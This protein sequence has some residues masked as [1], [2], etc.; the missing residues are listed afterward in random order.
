MLA[1]W[2]LVIGICLMGAMTPGASLAVVL[3]QSLY[4]GRAAGVITSISHAVG[5][6]VYATASLLGLGLL[7]VKSPILFVAIKWLGAAYL[8]W[9]AINAWRFAGQSKVNLESTSQQLGNPIKQGLAIS[10][11]NP[12]VILFFLALFSQVAGDQLDLQTKALYASTAVVIDGAWYTLV[13]L[14]ATRPAIRNK[15][16][17]GSL[18]LDRALASLLILV[19]AR[20]A[21][22]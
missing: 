18:W 10:L 3:R 22:G 5:I 2:F 8:V 14:I 9:M 6:G 4:Q 12:K 11:L 19:A 13:A 1:E 21:F 15:L 17:N 16:V 20:I 7:I